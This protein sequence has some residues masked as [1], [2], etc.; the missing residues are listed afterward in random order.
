MYPVMMYA[1]MLLAYIHAQ[2][3]NVEFIQMSSESLFLY[4]GITFHQPSGCP[5][6]EDLLDFN[7]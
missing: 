3:H 6:D 2:G 5:V 4:K 7:P 1:F